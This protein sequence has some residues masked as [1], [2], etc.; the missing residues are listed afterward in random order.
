MTVET[1]IDGSCMQIVGLE[2]N[3]GVLVLHMN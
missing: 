3:K 2:G 1:R